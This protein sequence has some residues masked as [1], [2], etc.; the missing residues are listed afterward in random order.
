MARHEKKLPSLFGA[1]VRPLQAFFRLEA[2]SAILL[3]VAAVAALAWANSAR[4]DSYRALLDWPLTLG[5]GP[6]AATFS[7]LHLVNDGLMT[8]FFFVVGM[9]IKRELV[10]GELRTPARAALPAVA[11]LGGMLVPAAIYLAFNHGGPGQ[12]G[13]GIPMATDIAFSIGCLTLLKKRVSYALVVFLTALAIFDDIG[14][15]IV[16]ALFY[17]HGLHPEWLAGLAVCVVALAA[18][19]RARVVNG[20]AWAAMGVLLW[21]TVHHTGIH[22]AIAG[23]ILGLAVPARARRSPEAVLDDL[24]AYLASL[25]IA[26]AAPDVQVKSAELM[27]I[28]EKLEDVE[29]PLDRFVHLWHPYVAFG[30]MPLFALVNSG[31]AVGTIG[32]AELTGPV[33]LGTML[34]LV[35][36]KMIGVFAFTMAVVTLGWAPMPA[37]ASPLKLLG[38]STVAGIGFTVALFIAALAF[39]GDPARLDQAK[40]GILLGS[41]AAGLLGAAL[42]RATREEPAPERAA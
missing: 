12:A 33:A 38:V 24:A 39:P 10:H 4:A 21:F 20:L 9:E 34:G 5:A 25:K 28:E 18:M 2:A 26:T 8:L 40:L 17:G 22:A 30:V 31:V 36:G 23:V 1:V 14:G 16:I 11:A 27:M 19:N 7:L 15:I 6:A 42:L 41:A 32:W 3:F 13:W 35:L 29:A 37:S